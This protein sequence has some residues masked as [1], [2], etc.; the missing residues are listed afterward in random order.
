MGRYHQDKSQPNPTAS[1]DFSAVERRAFDHV[2]EH[3]AN[4][5]LCSLWDLESAAASYLSQYLGAQGVAVRREWIERK[6][7]KWGAW[8]FAK[9]TARRTTRPH[10]QYS[11]AQ[12][13]RGRTVAAIRKRGR[14]DWQALRAQL[15]RASG[16]TV[17][18]VAAALDCSRRWV[19]QL[20]RRRFSRLVLAALVLALGGVNVPKG[21]AVATSEIQGIDQKELLPAF[22]I[23][24]GGD[25]IR[26]EVAGVV[27]TIGEIERLG[28]LIGDLLRAHLVAQGL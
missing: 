7:A 12:A 20:S 5:P 14:T 25:Q 28:P 27:S 8:W 24:E 13:L 17:A 6:A 10:S 3:L 15:A 9:H 11:A 2:G 19:F 26:P 16:G 22:T 21:S 23:D 18:E 1:A 4:M